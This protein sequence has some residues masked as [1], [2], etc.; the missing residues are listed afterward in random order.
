VSGS[1]ATLEALELSFRQDLN[2]D[3]II[4]MPTPPPGTFTLTS[5]ADTFVGSAGGNIVYGTAATLNAGDSLTGGSGNNLLQLIG[6]GYFDLSQLAKFTGFNASSS[7]MPQT[8]LPRL[9]STTSRSRW[10]QQGIC[11][12]M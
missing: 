3:R 5:G 10:M 4:G 7:T 9:L 1:S 12:S 11:R 2:G 8:L 6:S